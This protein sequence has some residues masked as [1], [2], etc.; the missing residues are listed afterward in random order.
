MRRVAQLSLNGCPQCRAHHTSHWAWCPWSMP[1]RNYERPSLRAQSPQP[2]H[3]QHHRQ[4]QISPGRD[5]ATSP[6]SRQDIPALALYEDF[7]RAAHR[8]AAAIQHHRTVTAR[9]RLGLTTSSE[10][11]LTALYHHGPLTPSQLAARIH[12]TPSTTTALVDQ[13][14]RAGHITRRPHPRDRRKILLSTTP[15]AATLIVREWCSFTRL[16][17]PALSPLDEPTQRRI[18]TALITAA[19]ALEHGHSDITD[20][21]HRS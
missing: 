19:Q 8:L 11:A 1:V 7:A 5:G 9:D 12:L 17:D 14:D 13:L 6:P 18:T 20:S 10:A 4:G 16:L 2:G 15:A 3:A 21:T